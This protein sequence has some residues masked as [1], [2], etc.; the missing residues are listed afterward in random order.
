MKKKPRQEMSKS[1]FTP[2]RDL[3]SAQMLRLSTGIDVKTGKFSTLKYDL[4][5]AIS[6]QKIKDCSQLVS[7]DLFSKYACNS[8]EKAAAWF[9]NQLPPE[10]LL[11]CNDPEKAKF[12]F[13][14][15]Y[16]GL[17][18]KIL[19]R[20]FTEQS[21]GVTPPLWL[22]DPAAYL[23][24]L[25]RTH[26]EMVLMTTKNPT[27][28]FNGSTW[29]KPLDSEEISML[30]KPIVEWFSNPPRDLNYWSSR[31][32]IWRRAALD[33][34]LYW[35]STWCEDTILLPP[36]LSKAALLGAIQNRSRFPSGFVDDLLQHLE[37]IHEDALAVFY[38]NA[39]EPKAIYRG[40]TKID[41]W[42]I[43]VWPLVVLQKWN[44]MTIS[45]IAKKRFRGMAPPYAG[46]IARCEKLNL[47]LHSSLR[48]GG[49]KNSYEPHDP[50]VVMAVWINSVG[51]KENMCVRPS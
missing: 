27:N 8:F 43:E 20:W 12:L 7:P 11:S 34:Y 18:A 2:P 5:K 16:C 25:E 13:Q 4:G 32:Q 33:S 24:A 48:R 3:N 15:Y 30:P 37:P 38:K 42:L 41:T 35:V 31:F 28:T 19:I 23:I 51:V 29:E 44:Y 6:K 47:K 21:Q 46:I 10:P 36:S 50:F 9:Y 26:L 17:F 39:A 22:I 49:V 1:Q 45:K 40:L 14:G